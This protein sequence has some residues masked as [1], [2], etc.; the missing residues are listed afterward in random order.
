M[1]SF[2]IIGTMLAAA[3][4]AIALAA[5]G[6]TYASNLSSLAPSSVANLA[7]YGSTSGDIA[8]L[9]ALDE[10]GS[11]DTPANYVQLV[12]SSKPYRANFTFTLPNDGSVHR[13][14][15]QGFSLKAN[16]RV[17]STGQTWTFMLYNWKTHRYTKLGK[18][19][20]FSQANVWSTATITLVYKKKPMSDFVDPA[21][22]QIRAQ[23]RGQNNKFSPALDFLA[24][25]VT[26]PDVVQPADQP[27]I[28]GCTI[29][30]ADNVW[31]ARVD[32]L[33]VL[34]TSNK[35]VTSLGKGTGLHP[36]FDAIGDGIPFNVADGVTPP[37]NF[38]EDMFTYGDESDLGDYPIPAGFKQEGGGDAHILT[39]DPSNC[40]LYELYAA[41]ING[42]SSTAGSGAVWDLS[43]NTMRP[44]GWTSADAAGL[45]I[46]PGLVRYDEVASGHIN[47]ALRFTSSKIRN[48]Y[49]WPASHMAKCNGGTTSPSVPPMGQRFRLKASYVIPASFD[50]QT[51]VVL[52]ALKE[53]G[54]ILADCGSTWY[55]SGEPSLNWNDDNLVPQLR[56]VTGAQFEAVDVSS[57]KV[58]GNRYQITP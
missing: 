30:P 19:V 38:T 2:R 20:K 1:K 16:M 4:A 51:K 35:Y 6:A 12:H 34:K 50:P 45:P 10:T 29:F 13:Y 7:G 40:H 37:I 58:A 22:R 17:P 41:D 54:M 26:S 27:T 5:P 18:P 52:T 14:A 32:M 15:V 55:I 25:V 57:L 39:V 42:A 23:I 49:I 43:T 24:V 33:P 28:A 8:S 47:H 9:A 46:L 11:D 53:Y 21:T 44:L 36:D 56:S 3:V 48:S 31:N